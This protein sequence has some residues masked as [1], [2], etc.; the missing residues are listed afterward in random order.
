MCLKPRKET[1]WAA[2]PTQAVSSLRQSTALH[3]LLSRKYAALHI[4]ALGMQHRSACNDWC[5]KLQGPAGPHTQVTKL[6][7]NAQNNL[8]TGANHCWQP[9]IQPRDTSKTPKQ[10]NSHKQP[11]SRMICSAVGACRLQQVC[12]V[13]RTRPIMLVC[14]GN[15]HT[16]SHFYRV[17]CSRCMRARVGCAWRP[18]ST[19]TM[20][21]IITTRC[22]SRLS[23]IVTAHHRPQI[24][25]L[26]AP[27]TRKAC[28]QLDDGCV[29]AT[30][31]R[32]ASAADGG[33]T[34]HSVAHLC[35]GL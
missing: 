12:M 21:L 31:C 23:G 14:A 15:D 16:V 11:H 17:S 20:I 3:A 1:I 9:A 34:G 4:G 26:E 19:C 29:L 32:V 2:L 25:L 10:T 18:R 24:G 27:L 5:I 6:G 22:S 28:F 8:C 13:N 30:C 7:S 35:Q 33:I